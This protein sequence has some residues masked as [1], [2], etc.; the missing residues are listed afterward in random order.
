M[1]NAILI[2]VIGAFLFF[3]PQQ[4]Y[5]QAQGQENREAVKEK[6]EKAQEK[7]EDAKEKRDKAQDKR[8]EAK[9]KR[10]RQD[11]V[12]KDNQG[13]AYGRDKGDMTG[14]EFG[15]H[16][17]EMA[18]NKAKHTRDRLRETEEL[19]TLHRERLSTL[20]RSL[21]EEGQRPNA[22]RQ[23]IE[24]RETRIRRAELRLSQ[25][26]ESLAE[27]RERLRRAESSLEALVIDKK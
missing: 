20:K 25:L 16:R 23:D 6:Q 9:D 17:A 13:H 7:R 18:R 21:D 8:E 15:Q 14:R 24:E 12:S 1:K 3:T 22:N 26:E 2:S 5:A 27:S 4:S 19:I 10:E 11:R